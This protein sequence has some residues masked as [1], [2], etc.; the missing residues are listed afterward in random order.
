MS[1]DQFSWQD[2]AEH[3]D[4]LE[5]ASRAGDE[6]ATCWLLLKNKADRYR[7]P[8]TGLYPPEFKKPRRSYLLSAYMDAY[9]KRQVELLRRVGTDVRCHFQLGW[10]LETSNPFLKASCNTMGIWKEP[11]LDT[12]LGLLTHSLDSG[13]AGALAELVLQVPAKRAPELTAYARDA[14]GKGLSTF[15]N[16]RAV[17]LKGQKLARQ[18]AGISAD[19]G[20]TEALEMLGRLEE[21]ARL[22]STNS[23]YQIGLYG[24]MDAFSCKSALERFDRGNLPN[25]DQLAKGVRAEQAEHLRHARFWLAGAAALDHYWAAFALADI[26]KNFGS[27]SEAMRWRIR[28]KQLSRDPVA[29]ENG[30][31]CDY[32]YVLSNERVPKHWK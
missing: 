28:A 23:M 14:S 11:D 32:F 16:E 6:W 29:M 7:L 26:E 13:F 8:R 21:A 15:V 9:R 5:A 4:V 30:E 27:R 3:P 31:Q 24:Y 25:R 20:D 1:A 19:S 10:E 12:R 22:G 17:M 2:V 18:L